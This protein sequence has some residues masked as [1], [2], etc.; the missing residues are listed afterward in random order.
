M[1]TATNIWAMERQW[2]ISGGRKLAGISGSDLKVMPNYQQDEETMSMLVNASCC[3]K[4]GSAG[5]IS[6]CMD[7][8][9]PSH[10]VL[11]IGNCSIDSFPMT[12]LQIS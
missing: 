3:P 8:Q 5:K 11:V 4:F 2:E 6:W 7:F 10:L 9:K 1:K 12:C